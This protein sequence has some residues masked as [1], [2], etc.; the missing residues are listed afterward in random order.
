[1]D[2]LSCKLRANSGSELVADDDRH[3]L[4]RLNRLMNVWY[5]MMALTL[6][7]VAVAA[8]P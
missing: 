4:V 2:W 7:A 1:M 8:I 3:A 6:T 5:D